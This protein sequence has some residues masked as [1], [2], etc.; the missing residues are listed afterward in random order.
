MKRIAIL[1]ALALASGGVWRLARACAPDFYR[2]VFTYVRH[3]DLPRSAFIDGRLGVLQPTFARSYLTI[4]YRYLNGIGMN[5]QEREQARDYYAD[6]GGNWNDLGEDWP[7]RWR[8]ARARI[9]APPAPTT[10]LIGGGQLTYDPETHSFILNCAEDAFRVALHTLDERRR[11]FG[12]ASPAFRSWLTAQ[13]AVF[14]NCEERGAAI[15][16]EASSE[17]PP[18]IRADREYQTAAALFY[19]ADYAHALERFRHIGRDA[20]SPWSAISRY[21]AVRTMLRQLAGDELQQE[22]Q[23]VL[24]DPKLIAVHGMTWNLVQRAGIRQRD[25]TY[26]R[27]LAGLLSSKGQ[28]DGLL[29]ELWN[30]TDLY[31]K[32]IGDSDPNRLFSYPPAGSP[33]VSHFRDA[34]L[35]DWIFSFQS[36]DAAAFRHCL[37]RWRQTRSAA[38]MLAALEHAT[39]PQASSTGLLTAAG[40]VPETSPA[41]LTARFHI[42]RFAL[43][44]GDKEAARNGLDA[45]LAGPALRDLPSSTN[46]FR[47]LRMRSAPTFDDF[48]KFA[49]RRPV[50]VTPQVNLGE[51]PN[52]SFDYEPLHRP[53]TGDLFDADATRVLNRQTPFRY[54]KEAALSGTLPADIRREALLTAFTRGLMLGEDLSEIA[55][56]MAPETDSYLSEQSE[57]GRR[58]EAA[59]LLLHHPEARPYFASGITRQSLPGKLDPYRDNWWCP[60]D[61]DGDLD[62]F[63]TNEWYNEMPNLLQKSVA[64]IPDFLSGAAAGDAK[65]EMDRLA[66][67]GA[68]TDFLGGVVFPYA[69]SHRDDA[70]VPEA[71]YWLVRAGHYGCVDVNSWKVT[72]AAFQM[73][74]LRYPASS[75]TKRTPTWVKREDDI[76]TEVERRKLDR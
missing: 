13:D 4:A 59:F 10:S 12:A 37:D 9:A 38:W 63:A 50:M 1:A 25:Q 21:L 58:F 68:A 70:R 61:I 74:H 27:A 76:R 29:E 24:D 3:P 15:P 44:S 41:Y 67:L 57:D 5:P 18:L 66:K 71:L 72:R 20:A 52:F 31:D 65:R 40:T 7:K 30:Y 14:A 2:A 32:M 48:M 42:S 62:S 17:L 55:R 11:Q 8:I 56:E 64:S 28:D 16:Q 60:T 54:L 39:A 26:F 45:L 73:L 43:D 75:W 35:S 19:A 47:G 23:A 6:R 53:K 46:L 51:E 69:E 36:R 34:D 22:A 33:D 49:L